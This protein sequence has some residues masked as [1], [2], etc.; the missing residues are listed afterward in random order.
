M[1]TMAAAGSP[2]DDVPP[3]RGVLDMDALQS[4][5]AD[6]SDAVWMCVAPPSPSVHVHVW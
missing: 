1:H 4:A 2:F 6:S 5:L 3:P